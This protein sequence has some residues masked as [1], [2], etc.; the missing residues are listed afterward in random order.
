MLCE[1]TDPKDPKWNGIADRREIYTIAI[2]LLKQVGCKFYP[3]DVM[4]LSDWLA[5]EEYNDQLTDD[6]G[7]PE[8]DDED[9]NEDAN[10]DAEDGS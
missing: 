1:P 5:G 2:A 4:A 10:D 8:D 6:P 9:E 7:I 3:I